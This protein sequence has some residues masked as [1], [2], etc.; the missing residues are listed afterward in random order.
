M[1]VVSKYESHMPAG[2][3]NYQIWAAHETLGNILIAQSG[4][5]QAGRK[6]YERAHAL[7]TA[8]GRQLKPLDETW[9]KKGFGDLAKEGR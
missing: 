8:S 6:H 2:D 4:S 3:K 1:Q 7:E 5:L 9:P